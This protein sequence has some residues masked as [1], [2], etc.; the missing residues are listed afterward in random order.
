[1]AGDRAK[2]RPRW[3]SALFFPAAALYG[4]LV[5][6]VSVQGMIAADA[7]VPALA[8]RAAHARE[9]LF[10][11]LLAVVAGYLLGRPAARIG[12]TLLA[13]WFAARAAWLL[14]PHGDAALVLQSAFALALAALIAPKFTG[15]ARKLRNL[16]VAPLIVLLALAAP[17]YDL[18]PSVAALS[19]QA[20][21]QST[22][23]LAAWLMAF[24]GGRLIA[25]AV[26]GQLERQGETLDARVQ[27]RVEGALIVVLAAAALLTVTGRFATVA[28]AL[29]LVGAAL[30]VI[31]TLRW[32]FWRCRG[33]ADLLCLIAGYAWIAVGLALLGSAMLG[34]LS[35]GLA[36]HALTVGALGTLTLN[37]MVRT[38]LQ[39][40]HESPSGTRIL[41]A[42]T[43][44]VALAAAARL[45]PALHPAV[46]LAPSLAGAAAAWSLACTLVALRLLRRAPARGRG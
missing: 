5:V 45:A 22:V 14:W 35:P 6:P 44:L 13:L 37:V 38:Q 2:S 9:L 16:S 24:M 36:V 30:V 19:R 29:A 1:M 27:P 10:G 23:L 8:T 33:R 15:A 4:A 31:R 42:V 21:A 3:A 40:G 41:P 12:W 46:P 28:G 17:A 25:P 18:A 11:F 26:A 34:V 20:V 32:R 43:L 7:W 39:R